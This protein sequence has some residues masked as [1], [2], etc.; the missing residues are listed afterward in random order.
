VVGGSDGS[1]LSST[2]VFPPSPCSLPTLGEGRAGPSLSLLGG[3]LVA[4]GGWDGSTALSYCVSWTPG[5]PT[6]SSSYTMR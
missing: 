4:C 6:W 5:S 3:S 2:S 1:P